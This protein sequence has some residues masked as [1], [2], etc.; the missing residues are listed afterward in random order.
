MSADDPR[1]EKLGQIHYSQIDFQPA[2]AK[3]AQSGPWHSGCRS[4]FW[5]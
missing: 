4:E 2:G 5:L 3:G 1:E